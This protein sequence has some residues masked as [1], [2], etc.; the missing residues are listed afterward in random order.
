MMSTM[1]TMR[2]CWSLLLLLLLQASS[3]SAWVPSSSSSSTSPTRL[4][5]ASSRGASNSIKNS[6]KKFAKGSAFAQPAFRKDA[7]PFTKSAPL[8]TSADKPVSTQSQPS[9]DG[10]SDDLDGENDDSDDGEAMN[11][12]NRREATKRQKQTK[13]Q[14]NGFGAKPADGK[15]KTKR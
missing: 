12:Q 14:S 11:R 3:T 9:L 15:T 4:D 6:N 2:S 10:E 1:S 8:S 5:A 7:H 13:P